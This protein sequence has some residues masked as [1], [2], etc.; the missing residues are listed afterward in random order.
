MGG[1]HG[2]GVKETRRQVIPT[3]YESGDWDRPLL[4]FVQPLPECPEETRLAEKL[5]T[6]VTELAEK[7]DT[8]ITELAD[9]VTELRESQNNLT[10]S[11]ARLHA[12]L[13]SARQDIGKLLQSQ[14]SHEPWWSGLV[15]PVGVIATLILVLVVGP[16]IPIPF[17]SSNPAVILPAT[18][19]IAN[20]SPAATAA[21]LVQL[22]PTPPVVAHRASHPSRHKAK[23]GRSRG[24]QR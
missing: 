3:R 22:P 11:V 6:K 20:P 4:A 17:G 9:T 12:E 2:T 21:A 14:E 19:P 16:M 7:L 5:S 8:D 10:A 18:S 24:N 15:F 23:T 1:D 13:R